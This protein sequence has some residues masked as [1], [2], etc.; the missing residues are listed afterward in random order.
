MVENRFHQ[1]TSQDEHQEM[2]QIQVAHQSNKNYEC[3]DYIF[4]FENDYIFVFATEVSEQTTIELDD[5]LE[6]NCMTVHVK[7]INGKTISIKCDKKQKAATASD[8]VER[9]SSILRGMT[10]LAHQGKVM[11]EK[12]TIEE[13]N[14]GAETTIEMFLRLLGGMDESDMKDSSETEEER[15]KKRKLEETSKGKSTKTSEESI[16]LQ[17]EIIDAIR[18]SE[19]KVDIYSRK[20]D[21]KM[22][23]FL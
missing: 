23:K 4:E 7:T 5:A 6:E 21:E 8:E 14:V 10:Y 22:D 16:F 2:W 12:K 13:N 20:T 17:R 15:E 11:N 18:K 3:D 19:E 9:T 1:D